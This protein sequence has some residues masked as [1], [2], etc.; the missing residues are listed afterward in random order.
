MPHRES[1][2]KESVLRIKKQVPIRQGAAH[3]SG[4]TMTNEQTY[5]NLEEKRREQWRNGDAHRR[6][7]RRIGEKSV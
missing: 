4:K 3:C 6:S 5:R 2:S 7:R 1:M